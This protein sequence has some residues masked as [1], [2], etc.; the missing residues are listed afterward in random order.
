MSTPSQSEYATLREHYLFELLSAAQFDELASRT[1]LLR[2][3]PGEQLFRQGEPAERFFLV[4]EGQIKLYRTTPDGNEKVV[5]I[6]PPGRSFAEATLFMDMKGYP[7]SA[8]AIANARV[9]AI[10]SK[11]YGELLRENNELCLRL[12]GSLSMRLHQR[13]N[14]IE[15]LSL[16][17]AR[18]RIAGYLARQLPAGAGDGT[19]LT[20][21]APK[22]II[23][24]QLGVTPETFSRVL[25]SLSE[26]GTIEVRAATVV[27]N[28]IAA[29]EEAS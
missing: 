8:A 2:L 17:N 21:A 10:P 3:N 18:H 5:E 20:L 12:L 6:M 9:F 19:E 23:A 27:V 16:Q 26:A 11:A 1:R 28:D 22:Q 25:R 4:L 13:L 14:E 15:I 29:L 24:S 7:A